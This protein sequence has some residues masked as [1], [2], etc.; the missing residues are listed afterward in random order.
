MKKNNF[1]PEEIQVLKD[2]PNVLRVSDSRITYTRA[3]KVHLVD[4][5]R[6]GKTPTQVFREAGF[7]TRV[8]GSK[9]IER[10]AANWKETYER[11]ILRL[12]M[13]ESI[14][15]EKVRI[16]KD[17]EYQL[18]LAKMMKEMEALKEQISMLSAR[19]EIERD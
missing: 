11:N 18:M 5:Y 16:G 7:D 13:G 14:V 6:K 3:F 2:N 10:A 19:L 12:E 17:E 1:T 4:E 9:R 15:Q 8:L